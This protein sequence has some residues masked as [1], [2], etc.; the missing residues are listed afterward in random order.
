M[1]F[2]FS[3]GDF[4]ATA[5]LINEI[6]VA[7]RSSSVSE[8]NELTLELHAVQR[9]L[10]EIEHLQ[11]SPGQELPVNA[12]KVAAL[13]CQH[14]LQEFAVKLNKF[15]SLG[16]VGGTGK[17]QLQRWKSK[18]QW[19]FTMEEEV[20]R[21]RIILAAHMA[22][23][24]VRLS[25]YGLTSTSIAT[26]KIDALQD[27]LAHTHNKVLEIEKATQSQKAAGRQSNS[28]LETLLS[29]VQHGLL[30]KMEVLIDIA[31]RLWTS[32]MQILNL[33]TRLQHTTPTPD[34]HHTYFQAPCQFEDGLGR[35]LLVPSEYDLKMLRAI[36]SAR[37]SSGPG[38]KKLE[39]GEYEI[40]NTSD[41]TQL[42]SDPDFQ[43]LVPGMK[44]T[45]AFIIGR[46]Q[47]ATLEECPRPGC[48]ARKFTRNSAGGRTCT[49]CDVWF[50]I[51]KDPLPRPFRLDP[52]EGTFHRLRTERKWYKNVKICHSAIPSLPPCVDNQGFWVKAPPKSQE[53]D[54][55]LRQETFCKTSSSL[56]GDLKD[57]GYMNIPE[58]VATEAIRRI[59]GDLYLTVAELRDIA[60]NE[61]E[62]GGLG[63]D[64]LMAMSIAWQLQDLG[65]T[66]PKGFNEFDFYD[67]R[68]LESFIR[69]LV[70]RYGHCL[71]ED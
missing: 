69:S 19:G 45:M 64:S 11:P 65:F 1:S 43:S 30:P 14:P 12:I 57:C 15:K 16:H 32:N 23:L 37:F 18:L 21:I 67:C 39:A 41:N 38:C 48:R 8:F 71:T 10:D 60:V 35:P 54:E 3:L 61:S 62:P 70:Q 4:L 44:I 68:F 42:L 55:R 29:L 24:N 56:E 51:S 50:D 34:V 59:A 26:R 6:I 49:S 13:L 7:L 58:N 46:Y 36:I 52:T 27:G 40:F 5:R 47:C 25:T 17:D 22:T 2:G 33:L 63:V 20:Q 9:S 66:A 53:V 31:N 28:Y